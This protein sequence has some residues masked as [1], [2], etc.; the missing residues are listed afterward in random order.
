[1]SKFPMYRYG[2]R[3]EVTNRDLVDRISKVVSDIYSVRYNREIT[4]RFV[5]GG[6]ENGTQN[7]AGVSETN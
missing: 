4:V 5:M 3:E 6:D 1:M 7:P 2:T